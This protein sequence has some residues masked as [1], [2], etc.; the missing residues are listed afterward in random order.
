MYDPKSGLFGFE[1]IADGRTFSSRDIRYELR[2]TANTLLGLIAAQKSGFDQPW[3]LEKMYETLLDWLNQPH[4]DES[5][6]GMLLACG[7]LLDHP[8]RKPLL[9]NIETLL[10]NKPRLNKISGQALGWLI[11]GLTEESRK[12]DAARNHAKTLIDFTLNNLYCQSS[13]L[14]YNSAAGIR[15]KFASFAI[16]SYLSFAL[17][18][19]AKQFDEPEIKNCALNAAAKIISLQGP[20]GQWGWM[21][22]VNKGTVAD[23]YPVFGVHQ[24][25]M[26][27]LFLLESGELGLE[28]ALP[29]AKKGFNWLNSNN[30]L[31]LNFIN[32]D[33]HII[34]RSLNRRE[35]LPKLMRAGRCMSAAIL[36]ASSETLPQSQVQLNPVCRP[37]HLGWMLWVFSGRDS[38]EEV[39]RECSFT[40]QT[41][42]TKTA[43]KEKV[44]AIGLHKSHGSSAAA[45]DENGEPLFCACE[46]RFTGIKLQRGM[47]HDTYNFISRNYNITGAHHSFARLPF[48]Q[49]VIREA[50]YYANSRLS[51]R[52]VPGILARL[53][54]VG[55]YF[56]QTKIQKKHSHHFAT[57]IKYFTDKKL[58]VYAEHHLT[59]AYSAYFQAG[60][61]DAEIL[62][63]D[64]FGDCLSGLHAS[65]KDSTIKVLRRFYHNELTA[66][67][68]YEVL[69]AMLG[70]HPDKH[71]GK[72]TGLAAYG[73]RNQACLAALNSFFD[74]QWKA[75]TKKNWFYLIHTPQERQML[76]ELR[77]LRKTE[78]AKFSDADMAYAIQNRLETSV[79]SLIKN[80]IGDIPSKNIVLAGGVFANVKLNQ[81]IHELGFKNTFVQPAMADDGCSL[82]A[83]IYDLA[84]RN[85]IKPY[86]LRHVYLGPEYCRQEIKDALD[87]YK[88]DYAEPENLEKKVA[89]LLHAGSVV[90]RFDGR[91]EFGPRALGNRTILCHTKEKKIND[92]LNKRLKRTE[93]MPFAPVTLFEERGRCY[94]GYQGANIPR[95]S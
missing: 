11:F 56:I 55:G 82:G 57:D 59:H 79:I 9:K 42:P 35:R 40:P 64:G 2:Y 69:T 23:F 10:N 65:G 76:H 75:K 41:S 26:A 74:S 31:N 61:D 71:P 67:Q 51:N 72:I 53:K 50:G 39:Y 93:F 52:Y 85:K 13:H 63:I 48:A 14:F 73:T 21:Y 37:Y 44:A 68:D 58:D 22:D 33:N 89:E 77:Q 60:L 36:C 91:M 46:E 27:P 81:R 30:E 49:R 32:T 84:L 6:W 38:A 95:N 45:L 29:A 86:R 28:Q 34:Y 3:N 92:W 25:A 1:V 62:T 88:L 66:G 8:G 15:R 80:I 24:D 4:F 7:A 43:A 47:P 83:A 19:A 12:T 87:H 78:F 16:Q 94:L 70:F 17:A 54:E 18:R 5:D 90:A 20:Q